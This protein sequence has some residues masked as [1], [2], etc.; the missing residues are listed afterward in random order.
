MANEEKAL[1][2]IKKVYNDTSLTVGEVKEILKRLIEEIQILLET[3]N[4]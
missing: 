2:A 1:E 3:L 4:I